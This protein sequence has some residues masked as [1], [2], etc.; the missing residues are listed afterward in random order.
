[1][2]C[3]KAGSKIKI[4][5]N[6]TKTTK[7]GE[8]PE[9][10]E[11]NAFKVYARGLGLHP[12]LLFKEFKFKGDSIRLMGYKTRKNSRYPM[13]FQMNGQ[14]YKA[15]VESFKLKLAENGTEYLM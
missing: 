6:K 11:S 1:M 15:S 13:Q 4:T 10:K 9:T 3:Q 7:H 12:S 8:F 14:S 2:W 5:I